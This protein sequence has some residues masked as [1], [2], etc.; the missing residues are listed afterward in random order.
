MVRKRI[1]LIGVSLVIFEFLISTA[2]TPIRKDHEKPTESAIAVL[3]TGT[4]QLATQ[5][6]EQEQV[7]DSQQDT[8]SN[9]STQIST[10]FEM[11]T[12]TPTPLPLDEVP[13]LYPVC[14]PPACAPDEMYHCPGDC[15][16]GCGTVCATAT[17]GVSTGSGQGFGGICFPG[18]TTPE[19]TIYFQ[20]INTQQTLEFPVAEGQD[21]YQL[22][23]PAGVYVAFAWLPNKEAGGG[24]TQ[25]VRCTKTILECTDHILVPFLVQENHVTVGVDICD[26]QGD[27]SLFPALPKK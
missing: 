2:C 6:T 8:I 5:V 23:I 3:G 12:K 21:S 27:T 10:V 14:T 19:M 18:E 11:I 4:S 25:F 7:D 15:P 26:W 24:Y 17:P 22:N 13:T 20:E 9:L 16:G 1:W